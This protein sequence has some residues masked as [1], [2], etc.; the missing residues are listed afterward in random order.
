[1]LCSGPLTADPFVGEGL[2]R[3]GGAFGAGDPVKVAPAP[4]GLKSSPWRPSPRCSPSRLR[5]LHL[6]FALGSFLRSRAA[7]AAPAD[8]DQTR[9]AIYDALGQGGLEPVF[10]P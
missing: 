1:M 3:E 4:S 10:S 6:A 2:V 5:G 7:H 9:H 8:F